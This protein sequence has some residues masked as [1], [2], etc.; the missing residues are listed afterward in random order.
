MGSTWHSLKAPEVDSK[1]NS[2][3]CSGECSLHLKGRT[4]SNGNPI[5]SSEYAPGIIVGTGN[6]GYYL[7]QKEKDINT[8]LSRDGGHTWFEIR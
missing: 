6:T 5:Y 3:E 4:Q 7:G 1:G 8:Y 2:I